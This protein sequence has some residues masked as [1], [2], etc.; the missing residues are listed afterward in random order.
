MAD[1]TISRYSFTD[2]TGDGESGNVIN[3]ALIAA[4][5]YDKID[6]IFS[7]GNLAW[8][9]GVTLSTSS[10]MALLASNNTF[11]GYQ[12]VIRENGA[13][14]PRLVF[15]RTTGVAGSAHGGLEW[16]D[17]NSVGVLA[18]H[19]NVT[20]G[21]QWEWNFWTGAAWA[22]RM[23]LSTA[24]QLKI[25]GDCVPSADNVSHLGVAGTQRWKDIY[26]VTKTSVLDVSWG[27]GKTLV[28]VLEGPEYKLYDCGTIQLDALG[29]GVVVLGPKFRE[30][31]NTENVPYQ[32]FGGGARV[33]SKAPGGFTLRGQPNDIVDW[34]VIATR[35]G[36]E[37][38]RFRDLASDVEPLGLYDPWEARLRKHADNNTPNEPRRR[39]KDLLPSGTTALVVAQEI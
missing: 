38:V 16:F 17:L 18:L 13:N 39:T 2:D 25:V 26:A 32:A 4:S 24:G 12:Q 5:I 10:A 27:S 15:S 19:A 28:A 11:T 33:I 14:Y 7:T 22:M 9:G 37:N 8:G 29:Q 31:T 6:L 21:S 36:F 1:T 20:V 23:T 35:A 30:V 3:A 34:M